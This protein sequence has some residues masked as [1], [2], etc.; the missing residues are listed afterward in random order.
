MNAHMSWET[1]D[2]VDGPGRWEM[3]VCLMAKAP[4]DSCTVDVTPRRCQK[5]APKPGEKFRWTNTA[6]ADG[7]VVGSGSL[8]A[9]QYGLVIIPKAVVSKGKNRISIHNYPHCTLG[10]FGP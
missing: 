7:K 5:F 2:I 10:E 4:K 3:T 1:R 6:L 9:D 8:V